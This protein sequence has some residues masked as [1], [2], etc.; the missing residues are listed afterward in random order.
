MKKLLIVLPLL[1]V[2]CKKKEVTP[3]TPTTCNCYKTT[4]T[5]GAGGAYHYTSQTSPFIDLCAK[6]GTVE[7]QGTGVYKIVWTCN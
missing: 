4:Y 2:G 3:T 6:N 7:Y 5:I 1:I